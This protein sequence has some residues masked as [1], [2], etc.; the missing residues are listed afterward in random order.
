MLMCRLRSKL[1][2]PLL[3]Q[4]LRTHAIRFTHGGL[5]YL[6]FTTRN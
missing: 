3:G 1:S 2:Y 6:E 4:S 5:R